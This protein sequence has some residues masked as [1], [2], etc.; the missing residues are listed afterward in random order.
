MN[1]VIKKNGITYGII[2]GVFSALITATVYAIDLHLF[3]AWWL[4]DFNDFGLYSYWGYFIIK[5]K[6]GT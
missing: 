2:S 6:K 3:T 1:E 5:N 4:G